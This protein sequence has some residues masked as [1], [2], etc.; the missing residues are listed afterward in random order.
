[1][2]ITSYVYKYS[3]FKYGITIVIKILKNKTKSRNYVT[4]IKTLNKPY[5]YCIK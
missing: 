2:I 1:M 4:F 5:L 3:N